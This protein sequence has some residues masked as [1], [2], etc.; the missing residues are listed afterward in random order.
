M[1][2]CKHEILYSYIKDVVQMPTMDNFITQAGYFAQSNATKTNNI[3]G[4]D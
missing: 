2:F 1:L 4:F 3:V